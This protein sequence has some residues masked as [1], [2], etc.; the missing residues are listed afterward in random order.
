VGYGMSEGGMNWAPAHIPERELREVYLAP[1]E[2]AVRACGVESIMNSYGELDGLACGAS[3][4]LLRDILRDEWGFKGTVVS[5]YFAINMLKEYHHIA[6]SKEEA[7]L[8]ALKAG[9]DVELP[10]RDVYAQPV[11][12]A[13]Q[14]GYLDESLVDEACRRL[15]E[16]KFRLGLFERPYV[17][18]T[19]PIVL[20]TDADRTLARELAAK[21]LVLLKNGDP[22]GPDLQR[23][24]PLNAAGLNRVAVVGP[25][26]ES[27]RNMIGDY[28]YPC[29]IETLGNLGE[30]TDDD[31]NTAQPEEEVKLS[32]DFASIVTV[33]DG[34]KEQLGDRTEV[35]YAAGCDI[36]EE[37][38]SGHAEAVRAA[39]TSD[40]V[41]A[42]MGDR[43]GLVN[44]CTSG[45]SRDR[46][47]ITLPGT[48]RLLL[49]RLVAT[50]K[51][52]VLVMMN[53]RPVDLSWEA[54]N[55]DAILAAWLPG[56]EGGNAVAQAL[57]GERTPGGKLPMSFPRHVGQIPVF[58]GHKPSGGR[59]HWAGRYVETGT[60]PL[61][62]FGYGLSY[63]SF[64]LDD[65]TVD[66]ATLREGET[67]AVRCEV[68]NRGDRHGDEVVQ[69]YSRGPRNFVT[70]PV[71][72]LR[73]FK[74]VSL[75]PGESAKVTFEV[76]WDQFRFYDKDMRCAVHPGN[77]EL[78]LGTSS[79]DIHSRQHI[80]LAAAEE[81]T[82]VPPEKRT[83]FSTVQAES[84]AFVG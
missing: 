36:L 17:E 73:G 48:Q 51:P 82:I 14:D 61:Y 37:D 81:G 49:K 53:A 12:D 25:N 64:G 56:E 6:E 52:V 63:T 44:G 75:A 62:P 69:L 18:D 70:R 57:F 33:L 71:R 38:E 16:S 79:R 32:S 46:V 39:E 19:T 4:Y 55:V 67:V 54:D 77:V 30:V 83:Y 31:M 59:S 1:F 84:D 60:D 10:S 35:T 58:H 47:D 68:T 8:L 27:W 26:A 3:S 34:I 41:I 76:A 9:I 7:A 21:S 28:A 22:E 65:I 74:R 20:D 11:I 80:V 78:M 13:V 2:A 45:E 42:V 50:G 40:V 66:R 23:P 15:L 5:D 24:L 29:H 43:S 72:E